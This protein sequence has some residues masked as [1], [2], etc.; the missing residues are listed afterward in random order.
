MFMDTIVWAEDGQDA[1]DKLSKFLLKEIQE[2]NN[3]SIEPE[4]VEGV[5]PIE[6]IKEEE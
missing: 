4:V 6:E 1:I 5:N 3:G 2:I